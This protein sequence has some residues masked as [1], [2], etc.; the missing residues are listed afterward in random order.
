MPVSSSLFSGLWIPLVTPFGAAGQVDH[1]ALAALVRDL[2]GRGVAGF[3]PC[4][5]T[6]EAAALTAEEQ[7]AV[8]DTTLASASGLPVVM[9]VGGYRLAGVLD[10]LQAACTRPVA[11]V[12]VAAPYYIRPSQDG[13]RAWFRALADASRVPLVLYDIPYRTGVR[14]ELSTLLALAEHP[15]IVALKDCGGDAAKTAALIADGRLAVLAGEDAQIFGS[16]AAGAAGAI[17]ASAHLHTERFA[18]VIALLRDGALQEARTLWQPLLPWV[19]AVFEEP[20]PGPI[21]G[22]LAQAGRMSGTL[23]A[24]MTPASGALLQ[25]LLSRP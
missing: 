12:L 4:G 22:L 13:L 23:R 21:K 9:G 11:G 18:R 6:G 8:L 14:L 24:P 17:A 19:Q 3:V 20:N 15:R 2:C 7:L 10:A 1:A 16:V 25:R 5:S